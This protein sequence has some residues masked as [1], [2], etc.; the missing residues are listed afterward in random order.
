MAECSCITPPFYHDDYESELI[1]IDQAD[2]R[3][4]EISIL[5]CRMC[6]STWLNYFIEYEGYEHSSRWY[7]GMVT[8]EQL[9]RL[10]PEQV[11]VFFAGLPWYFF[12]EGVIFILRAKRV[13]EYL[14]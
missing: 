10:I 11:P 4:G 9:A 8:A 3:F 7:R 2:G 6:G 13:L 12:T 1:S 14:H 5:R